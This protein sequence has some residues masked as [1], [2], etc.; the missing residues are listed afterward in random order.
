M[1]RA[2][3]KL[4]LYVWVVSLLA[5]G[6]TSLGYC[7]D[8][9]CSGAETGAWCTVDCFC[10][11]GLCSNREQVY[12]ICPSECSSRMSVTGQPAASSVAGTPFTAVTQVQ[13]SLF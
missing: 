5:S 3:A 1:A 13:H 10:G 8:G 12:K 4:F 7:G 2:T 9:V 11:D 6:A